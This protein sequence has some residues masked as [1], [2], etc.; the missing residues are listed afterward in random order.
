MGSLCEAV[1]VGAC[2]S[3]R[4]HPRKCPAGTGTPTASIHIAPKPGLQLD[5]PLPYFSQLSGFVTTGD[6]E[7][8]FSALTEA[9]SVLWELDGAPAGSGDTLTR[10]LSVG[11]HALTATATATA[12]CSRSQSLAVHSLP[13]APTLPAGTETTT[14]D[15]ALQ[16]DSSSAA[17][18][19]CP[20]VAATLSVGSIGFGLTS[21]YLETDASITVQGGGSAR[22]LVY[23]RA[24]ATI[25]LSDVGYLDQVLV[26][27]EAGVTVISVGGVTPSR[28]DCAAITYD[29]SQVAAA[30]P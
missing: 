11:S 1:A 13:C 17:A 6:L 18:L 24:G 28:L 7:V 26:V 20:G 14:E 25:D 5:A 23:A 4:C 21:I 8:T 9:E 3:R 16:A 22:V 30:C 2:L 10:T 29:V 27:R 19:V 12:G 15:G